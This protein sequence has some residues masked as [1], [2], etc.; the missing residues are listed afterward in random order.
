MSLPRSNAPADFH[1]IAVDAAIAGAEA[2][3]KLRG[4]APLDTVR[5]GV[6]D[7]GGVEDFV[8][9]ADFAAEEAVVAVI[10]RARPDDRI[11]AEE[12]GLHDGSSDVE[13]YVDPLDG[14]A[15]FIA[16]KPAYAVSVAACRQDRTIASAVYRPADRRWLATAPEGSLQGN[17]APGANDRDSLSSATISLSRPHEPG[18]YREAMLLL[19]ALL[20]TVAAER[21][22]GSAACALL[23]VAT[24]RL[25]AYVSVDIPRWDTAAGHLLVER[26]EGCVRTVR[27]GSGTPVCIA[28]GPS[29][30]RLLEREVTR[31]FPPTS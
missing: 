16:D 26:A 28:A 4:G 3:R 15:N 6:S 27:L 22:V 5:L 14:T 13:W 7:K 9:A 2:I 12:S 31:Q 25:D 17:L 23:E 19:E 29:L 30:A 24:G 20:P 18:R 11:I 10:R 21:R 8:T 1:A